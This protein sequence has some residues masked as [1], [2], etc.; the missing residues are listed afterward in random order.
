MRR[1]EPVP[2]PDL[3]CK[4]LGLHLRGAISEL[5]PHSGYFA[6]GLT[7]ETA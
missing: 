2:I 5:G 6:S 1:R 7:L 3:A 4:G